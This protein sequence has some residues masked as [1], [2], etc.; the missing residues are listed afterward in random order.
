MFLGEFQ[1][2]LD[3]K[4][5]LAIPNELRKCWRK[6][7]HGESMV[8]APGE[9]GALWLWPEKTFHKLAGD[10][11]TSLRQERGMSDFQRRL[12]S[13]SASVSIDGAGRIRIPDR[14]LTKHGLSG[15]VVVIGAGEHM[16]LHSTHGWALELERLAGA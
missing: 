8:A 16:E 11:G 6:D 9:N 10:L 2:T 15:E 13:Q 1:H 3:A 5:R 14:M 4:Q 7:Q 12:F